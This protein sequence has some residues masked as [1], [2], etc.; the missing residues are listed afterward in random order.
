MLLILLSSIAFAG[1]FTY[2]HQAKGYSI[3]LTRGVMFRDSELEPTSTRGFVLAK[4]FA[5]NVL[6]LR[7]PFVSYEVDTRG[8]T[9]PLGRIW[10]D[11]VGASLWLGFGGEHWAPFIGADS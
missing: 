11:S 9:L 7:I 1:D 8:K 6:Q 10:A 2:N 4:E 5:P 3:G